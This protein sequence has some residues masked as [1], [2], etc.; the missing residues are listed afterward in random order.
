MTENVKGEGVKGEQPG[1][2]P[3]PFTGSHALLRLNFQPGLMQGADAGPLDQCCLERSS[4]APT[5][6]STGGNERPT[7]APPA[8]AK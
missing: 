8:D 3:P 6:A 4:F 1:I 5:P 2:T 7:F